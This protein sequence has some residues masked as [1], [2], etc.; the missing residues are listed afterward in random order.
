MSLR[1]LSLRISHVTLTP[2]KNCDQ[3]RI[4]NLI[5]YVDYNHNPANKNRH[6]REGEDMS[7]KASPKSENGTAVITGASSGI[8]KVYADRLAKRGYNLLLI[9]RRGDRLSE[10][11]QQLRNDQG[12]STETLV[13]TSVTRTMSRK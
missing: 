10:L 2:K 9:A 4:T 12:I 13:A 6:N 1:F 11:A 5:L 7:V 8:G 3:I